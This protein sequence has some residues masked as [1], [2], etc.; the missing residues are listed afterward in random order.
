MY[1]IKLSQHAA[2]QPSEMGP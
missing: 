1:N 2:R